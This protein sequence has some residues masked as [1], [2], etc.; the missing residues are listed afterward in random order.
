MSISLA[1]LSYRQINRQRQLV[2]KLPMHRFESM[3]LVVRLRPVAAIQ[4]ANPYDR[5][6]AIAE[7]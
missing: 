6:V 1:K 2:F 4:P 5:C 3:Q 7:L